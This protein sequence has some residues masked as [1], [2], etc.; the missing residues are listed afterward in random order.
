MVLDVLK[1]KTSDDADLLHCAYPVLAILLKISKSNSVF[2]SCSAES[3][4][5]QFRG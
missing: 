1:Q 3:F 2:V 5:C 4:V